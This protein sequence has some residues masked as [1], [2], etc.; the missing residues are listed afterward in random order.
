LPECFAQL[1]KTTGPAHYVL[2]HL[3]KGATMVGTAQDLFYADCKLHVAGE[4]IYVQRGEDRF[5]VPPPA[6]VYVNA[7]DQKLALL[8]GVSG[9]YE[10][11]IYETPAGGGPMRI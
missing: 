10:L 1:S 4:T 9:G 8:R 5:R 3:P 7:A 2:A 11:R 6:R